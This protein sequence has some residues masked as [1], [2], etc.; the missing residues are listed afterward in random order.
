MMLLCAE[1]CR[2]VD[3]YTLAG[4][5]PIDIVRHVIYSRVKKAVDD[6]QL[7]VFVL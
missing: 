6:G 4:S 2:V 5:L 1:G 3:D 7:R